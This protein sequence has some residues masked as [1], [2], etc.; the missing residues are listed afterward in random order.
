MAEGNR[1]RGPPVVQQELDWLGIRS[2]A[3][4]TYV[5]FRVGGRKRRRN[6]SNRISYLH[7]LRRL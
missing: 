4:E 3:E 5:S 6:D 7:R 2:V 1:N